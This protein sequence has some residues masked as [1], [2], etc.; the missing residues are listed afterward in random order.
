M[1]WALAALPGFSVYA[2]PPD[3]AFDGALN[4]TYRIEKQA[5]RLINGRSEVQAAPGSAIKITTVV[6]G[7]PAYGDL[8]HDGQEDAA[9]FLVHDPGGS[10][11]FYYVAA[12]IAAGGSYRG[13]NAVFI[14]DR[15]SPR[16][17][18]IRDGVIVAE[19]DDRSPD[20]PMAAAPSISKT[21]YL[22]LNEEVLTAIKFP[23]Q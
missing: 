8:N 12:A 18:Q 6:F 11:T 14:G 16:T 19:F 5:F 7:K 13:T 15:V 9:L 22:R 2:G 10:G 21:M 17:I 4:A 3:S 23:I 1:G 20:Q